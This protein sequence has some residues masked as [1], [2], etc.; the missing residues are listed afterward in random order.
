LDNYNA[1]PFHYFIKL[2]ANKGI[3]KKNLTQNIDNLEKKTE[4]DM[5]KYVVQAHGAN[6]GAA[7]AKGCKGQDI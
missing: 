5:D 7:C 4:I 6:R 3:L 1:T 2:L